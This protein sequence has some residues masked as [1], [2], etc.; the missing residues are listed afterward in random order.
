M[1]FQR[2]L[3]TQDLRSLFH[4]HKTYVLALVCPYRFGIACILFKETMKVS[5]DADS[6]VVLRNTHTLAQK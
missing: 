5:S 2:T 4:C 1:H 3:L 6:L